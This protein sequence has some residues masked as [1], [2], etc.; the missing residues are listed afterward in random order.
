VPFFFASYSIEGTVARIMAETPDSGLQDIPYPGLR[1][2]VRNAN[3]ITYGFMI[4]ATSM[5][6]VIALR[7]G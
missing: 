3:L 7:H 4:V 2:A 6:L 5:W 1:L